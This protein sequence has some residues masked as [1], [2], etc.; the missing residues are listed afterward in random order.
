[1]I[2]ETGTESTATG[3]ER[4]GF[5]QDCGRPLTPE[6]V[7]AVGSGVFCE[8]CLAARVSA[9]STSAY[10]EGAPPAPGAPLPRVHGSPSPALAGVLGFIPGVGAMYNGQYAKGLAHFAIFAVLMSLSDGHSLFGLMAFGWYCYQIFDA[11]H[12]AKAR[13]EGLPLPNP[14]GL[15]EIGDKMG[16][17]KNWPG[18]ASRPAGY[19][20]AAPPPATPTT[21]WTPGT[22]NPTAPVGTAPDW[23]GYV[24]PSAFATSP[25]VA[26][27][28]AAQ[29]TQAASWGSTPYS[30]PYT[31]PYTASYVPVASAPVTPAP[32]VVP[33]ARKRFPAGAFWLI[34]VGLLFTLLNFDSGLHI[35]WRWLLPV[36]LAVLA[37][38]IFVRRL[39]WLN[40][41]TSPARIVCI[42]RAPVML[43]VLA[44]LF[45]LHEANH[46]F[47]YQTWPV[48]L[49]AFGGLLLL[50]RSFGTHAPL[51]PR[52]AVPT[53]PYEANEV[54]GTATGEAPKE[55]Q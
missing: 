36:A 19:A 24:P 12:T 22:A 8:P 16:F 18:S 17:G 6:T 20:Q 23:V 34:G 11:Y 15:N 1:M 10:T 4:V 2:D 46:Y 3:G 41:D 47:L 48:L 32:A 35:S 51:Y 38:W 40:G 28:P 53:E 29:A 14:F 45:G 25:P 49:L 5:C 27:P 7:R 43:L 50:E 33:V 55:E 52:P 37:I 9:T 39:G 42:V 30:A 26:A 21:P 13:V 31:A 44:G 54:E